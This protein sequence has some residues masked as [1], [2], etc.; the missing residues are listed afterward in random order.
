MKVSEKT[1]E[2]LAYLSKLSLTKEEKNIISLDLEK[3][4][5]EAETMNDLNTDEVKPTSHVLP[6]FNVVREDVAVDKSQRED[7]LRNA[8]EK[9]DGYFMVPKAVEEGV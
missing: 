2:E 4:M 9:K 3:K 5:K 1:I 6:L 8:P 7:L